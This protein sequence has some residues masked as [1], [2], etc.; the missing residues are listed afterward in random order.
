MKILTSSAKLS[1]FLTFV[2]I[3]FC[4]VTI[5]VIGI[6][7][8]NAHNNKEKYKKLDKDSFSNQGDFHWPEGK[9]AAISLSFDDAR[10]NQVD[11]ALAILDRY[12]VKATFYVSMPNVRDRLPE[13]KKAVANGHEIGNHTLTHPCTVNYSFYSLSHRG[14]LEDFTLEMIQ[15][16][17]D[18]ANEGIQHLLGVRPTTFAYPC[19]QTFV[20]RGIT[21]KSYVPLVAARFVVGRGWNDEMPNVPASCDLSQ[22]MGMP[23]DGLNFAQARKLIDNVIANG[24]WLVLVGHNIGKRGFL[25][26]DS[27]TLEA[28]LQYAQNPNN[29]IYIDTVHAVGSYVLQEQIRIKNKQTKSRA[30]LKD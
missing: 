1:K 28:I 26:T 25:S 7:L 10:P 4:F 20:G 15:Q 30:S 14:G 27:S 29:G 13:W 12:G 24:R 8:L 5:V 17:M 3:I 11:R 2:V 16:E 6:Y 19:G 22:V 18:E 21:V 23:I 9:R